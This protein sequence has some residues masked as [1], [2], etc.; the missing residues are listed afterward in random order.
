MDNFYNL[1][2]VVE[3]GGK[4]GLVGINILTVQILTYGEQG[5]VDLYAAYS[6]VLKWGL[7]GGGILSSICDRRVAT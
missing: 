5:D 7:F 4:R 6:D 2:P 3:L 1:P